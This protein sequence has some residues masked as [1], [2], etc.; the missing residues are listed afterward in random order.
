[1]AQ[2]ANGQEAPNTPF[3]LFV[4]LRADRATCCIMPVIA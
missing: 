2:S 4:Q 3:D 1:M